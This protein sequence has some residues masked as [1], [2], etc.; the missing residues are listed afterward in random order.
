MSQ[1][2]QAVQTDIQ[3]VLQNL[4]TL[5]EP[6]TETQVK[7]KATS[8]VYGLALDAL[9]NPGVIDFQVNALLLTQL[10]EAINSPPGIYRLPPN[11]VY[12]DKDQ[13]AVD[14]KF[15][16]KSYEQTMAWLEALRCNSNNLP[17]SSKGKLLKAQLSQSIR[18]T[19]TILQN[20]NNYY[21]TVSTQAKLVQQVQ[22][23][24]TLY[25]KLDPE[26]K[27]QDIPMVVKDAF[28]EAWLAIM[29]QFNSVLATEPF[30]EDNPMFEPFLEGA[31]FLKFIDKLLYQKQRWLV[32]LRSFLSVTDIDKAK[33]KT[34]E[35]YKIVVTEIQ[36]KNSFKKVL[37]N[38]LQYIIAQV[39]QKSSRAWG[40]TKSGAQKGAEFGKGLGS[41][42]LALGS[43]GLTLGSKGLTLGSKGLTLGAKG[44]ALGSNVASSVLGYATEG[45]EDTRTGTR[46]GTAFRVVRRAVCVFIVFYAFI[47]FIQHGLAPTIDALMY[48]LAPL[49]KYF[50]E[51]MPGIR[52]VLS[53]YQKLTPDLKP[54]WL[55]YSLGKGAF[56]LAKNAFL[57]SFENWLGVPFIWNMF[58][59]VLTWVWNSSF[60]MLVYFFTDKDVVFTSIEWKNM[61]LNAAKAGAERVSETKYFFNFLMY[62]QLPHIP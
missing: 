26:A 6:F 18:L 20:A 43:K 10:K 56:S 30:G 35:L 29:E 57:W 3:K 51:F 12:Y 5:Y 7:E 21:N 39:Q 27:I 50:P 1:D 19:H 61:F 23:L 53:E 17:L 22:H 2:S 59:S 37:R 8:N 45:W 40:A 32:Y 38:A 34:T 24:F 15:D 36:L 52:E 47:L 14:L 54:G 28:V 48:V 9:R 31:D 25:K 13:V 4:T 60:N 62:I 16:S 33:Q 46:L 11:C 42:G 44:L 41:K 58:T 55:A 49:G